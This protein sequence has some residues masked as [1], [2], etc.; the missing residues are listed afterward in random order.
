MAKAKFER[1]KPHV[2]IGTIGHVDHGKTTLTAAITMALSQE[3]HA[4]AMRYDE[5]DKAPEEKARG[6]TINTAHV[7]YETDKR[8]YAHVDCPGHADYVK[9]VITGAVTETTFNPT[10]KFQDARIDRR[11]MQ[12]LYNDG[13]LY[14]FMDMESYDMIPVSKSLLPDNFKFVKEEMM[15]KIVSYK[16]NVFSVEPPMFVELQVTEVEPGFKGDTAQGAKKPATLETGATIQVPLFIENGEIL[17]ID[18]RTGE[19]LERVKT[20]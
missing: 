4:A 13:D 9:N 17:R 20:K 16:G 11:E 5:I 2:N 10:D 18:T 15:C 8:H 14:Y 7:E 12:Y 3:G 1:T 19:Y 6:I